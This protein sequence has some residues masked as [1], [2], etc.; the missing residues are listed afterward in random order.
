MTT[1]VREEAGEIR[2]VNVRWAHVIVEGH[3]VEQILSFNIAEAESIYGRP[4]DDEMDRHIQMGMFAIDRIALSETMHNVASAVSYVLDGKC[5]RTAKI[6]HCKD[7]EP[8]QMRIF[9][10]DGSEVHQEPWSCV[11]GTP[12]IPHRRLTLPPGAALEEEPDE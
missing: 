5:M 12:P 6:A 11:P 8:A 7:I 4:F 2:G 10:P 9:Q 1:E 3:T